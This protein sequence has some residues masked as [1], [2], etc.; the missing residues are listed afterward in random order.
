MNETGRELGLIVSTPSKQPINCSLRVING[1]LLAP[2][3]SN[4]PLGY[5]FSWSCRGVLL[6]LYNSARYWQYGKVI[7]LEI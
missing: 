5:R 2:E 6:A 4:N 1:A 3:V 7:P